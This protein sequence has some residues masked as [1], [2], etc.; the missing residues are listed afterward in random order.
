MFLHVYVILCRRWGRSAYPTC[1][2]AGRLPDQEADPLRGEIPSP[3]GSP[4]IQSTGRLHAPYWNAYLFVYD[5]SLVGQRPSSD[6]VHLYAIL[7]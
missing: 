2:G 1:L 6:F 3:E 5:S 4:P 7:G